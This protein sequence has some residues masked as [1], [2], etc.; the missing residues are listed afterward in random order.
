MLKPA[1]R[2][3]T[4]W[5]NEARSFSDGEVRHGGVPLKAEEQQ[6]AA[7]QQNAGC[8][9]NELTVQLQAL[10]A[11]AAADKI[12][13]DEEAEAT[14]DDEHTDRQ[15]HKRIGHIGCQE[16]NGARMPMRSKPALQ[17]AEM[18]WNTAA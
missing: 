6:P 18:A 10:P 1:V 5:K 9:Q 11:E 17:K 12:T 7:E 16:E 13:P 15:A 3:V 4:A 2:G 14:N 8:R